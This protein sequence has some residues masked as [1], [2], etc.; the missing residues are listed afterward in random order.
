MDE[1]S[2]EFTE[3]LNQKIDEYNK[4]IREMNENDNN[5]IRNEIEETIKKEVKDD[6]AS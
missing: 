3:V 5:I 2:G 1:K 4:E 6:S